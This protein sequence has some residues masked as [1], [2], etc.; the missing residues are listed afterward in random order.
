MLEPRSLFDVP[1]K[2]WSEALFLVSFRDQ[3]MPT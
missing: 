2:G 1:R 3:T